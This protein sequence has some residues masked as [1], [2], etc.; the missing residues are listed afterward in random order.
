MKLLKIFKEDKISFILLCSSLVFEVLGLIFYIS[1]QNAMSVRTQGLMMA[2]GIIAI[3]LTAFILVVQDYFSIMN[4]AAVALCALALVELISSQI[5]NL[6][7]YFAG[8]EDIGFGLMPTFIVSFICYLLAI[9]TS[10]VAV[11]KT[12]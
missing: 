8:I 5:V 1:S 7:Y 9:I 3:V 6:G 11:F 12:K 4:I 2:A 10:S